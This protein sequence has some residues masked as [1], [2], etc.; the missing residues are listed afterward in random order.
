MLAGTFLFLSI[1]VETDRARLF[2]QK[3]AVSVGEAKSA[4]GIHLS[5][6]DQRPPNRRVS[7]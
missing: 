1:K 7:I 5:P 2:L 3:E 4:N 6:P